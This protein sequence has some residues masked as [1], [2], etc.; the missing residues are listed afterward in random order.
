MK[1]MCTHHKYNKTFTDSDLII[2]TKAH[3]EY[4]NIPKKQCNEY[5]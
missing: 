5:E 1:K 4:P 2:Y 3:L